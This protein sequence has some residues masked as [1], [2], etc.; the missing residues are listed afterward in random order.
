MSAIKIDTKLPA[1][2]LEQ[3]MAARNRVGIGLPYRLPMLHRL[4]ESIP[5]LL[6]T[7]KIPSLYKQNPPLWPDLNYGILCT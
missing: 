2:N 1:R 7:L 4:A 3:S 5:G 6:K